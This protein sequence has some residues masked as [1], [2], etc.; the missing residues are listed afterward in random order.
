MLLPGY[1][2]PLGTTFFMP[3]GGQPPCQLD[4]RAPTPLDPEDIRDPV[5]FDTCRVPLIFVV[6]YFSNFAEFFL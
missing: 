2:E 4:L 6:P 5:E 3:C 1:M